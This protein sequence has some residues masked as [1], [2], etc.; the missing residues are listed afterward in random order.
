MPTYSQKRNGTRTARYFCI[1][2]PVYF[3]I[4]WRYI[5]EAYAMSSDQYILPGFFIYLMLASMKRT[6]M[7]NY[8]LTQNW[9]LF[10]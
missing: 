3:L 1:F 4:N 8:H 5:R 7:K 9:A 10:L 2:E 6:I